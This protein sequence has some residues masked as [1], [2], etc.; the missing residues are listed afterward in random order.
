MNSWG[1]NVLQINSILRIIYISRVERGAMKIFHE[2]DLD[3]E[4]E[5]S[6]VH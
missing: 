2:N 4:T 1:G 5:L 3:Q 6:T